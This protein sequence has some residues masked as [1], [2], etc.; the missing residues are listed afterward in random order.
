MNLHEF[1][2]HHEDV[3]R[4]NGQGPRPPSPER[5]DALWRLLGTGGRLLARRVPVGLEVARPDG[6]VRRV[7]RGSPVVRITGEPGELLLYL[8]DRRA[9]A[10]V[11]LTGPDEAVEAVR[12]ARFG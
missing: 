3:R 11:T 6:P 8:F 10:D 7:H 9:A 12:S 4:A 1:F 5:D 2:V